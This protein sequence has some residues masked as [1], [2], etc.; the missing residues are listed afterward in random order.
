MIRHQIKSK[1]SKNLDV[2]YL[3]SIS[4]MVIFPIV[5]SFLHF[6]PKVPFLLMRRL[7]SSYSHWAALG[8]TCNYDLLPFL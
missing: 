2:P 5:L 6:V 4:L 7:G 8:P 1:P 3:P